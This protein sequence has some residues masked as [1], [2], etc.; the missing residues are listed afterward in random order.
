MK[1][2]IKELV[3]TALRSGEYKQIAG[4]LR[5]GNCYCVEGIL[6]ELYRQQHPETSR[7][8]P[9]DHLAEVP[10]YKELQVFVVDRAQE[11]ARCTIAMPKEVL[12]WAGLESVFL[13]YNGHR[14]SI[15]QLNDRYALSLE[16]MADLIEEQL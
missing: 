10:E 14:T 2:E 5:N 12:N 11:D 3:L 15:I 6:C 1:P 16:Q 13:T 4:M 9:T 7:W 8:V